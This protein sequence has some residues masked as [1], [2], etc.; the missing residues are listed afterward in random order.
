MGDFDEA[1]RLSISPPGRALTATIDL[2]TAAV[3]TA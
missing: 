2:I 1:T 3:T